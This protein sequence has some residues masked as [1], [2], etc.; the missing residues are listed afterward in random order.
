M[1]SH[2]YSQFYPGRVKAVVANSGM[3][4]ESMKGES[5]LRN[6]L[7][8]FIASPS[9]FRYREMK[10][11]RLFLEANGWTTEWIEFPGGHVIAPDSVYE[12]VASWLEKHW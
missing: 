8:V 2:G 12:S 11:D 5:Y 10:S 9:D 6:K 7:A 4:E 3:I 1:A